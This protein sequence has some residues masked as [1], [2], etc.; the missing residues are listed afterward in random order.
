MTNTLSDIQR[1]SDAGTSGDDARRHSAGAGK[2]RP[3]RTFDTNGRHDSA[4][5]ERLAPPPGTRDHAGIWAYMDGLAERVTALWPAGVGA[6][7]AVS[8]ARRGR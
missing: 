8:D 7:E 2:H 5:T 1:S 3:A 6:A 4:P